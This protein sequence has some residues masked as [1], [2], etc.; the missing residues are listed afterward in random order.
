MVTLR[1]QLAEARLQLRIA[2]EDRTA[3]LKALLLHIVGQ[4]EAKSENVWTGV[5][6]KSR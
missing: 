4:Y 5:M 1:E 3:A 6:A 2:Y